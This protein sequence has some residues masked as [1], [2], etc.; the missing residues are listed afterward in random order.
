[1]IFGAFYLNSPQLHFELSKNI[2]LSTLYNF[3][4]TLNLVA[5]YIHGRIIKMIIIKLK[6]YAALGKEI[7]SP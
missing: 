4:V 7:K 1:M 2:V 5:T 3:S 6:A